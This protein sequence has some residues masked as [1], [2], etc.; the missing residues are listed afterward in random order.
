M[1]A[2][3]NVNPIDFPPQSISRQGF[4]FVCA[5]LYWE[6]IIHLAP[7]C[8]PVGSRTFTF[9]AAGGRRPRMEAANSKLPQVLLQKQSKNGPV[10]LWTK[11]TGTVCP[12]CRRRVMSAVKKVRYG[13]IT[14]LKCLLAP[15]FVVSFQRGAE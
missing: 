12:T 10:A 7:S 15:F 8:R 1:G 4:F 6:T 2:E 9:V 14:R 5:V 13:V 11:Q 3:L